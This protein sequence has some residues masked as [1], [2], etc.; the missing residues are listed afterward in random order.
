MTV[1]STDVAALQYTEWGISGDSVSLEELEELTQPLPERDGKVKTLNAMGFM[2]PSLDFIV[3][4]FIDFAAEAQYPVLDGGAAYG[5]ATIPALKAGATVIANDIDTRH[6]Q[7]IVKDQHLS[8]AEKQRLFLNDRALPNDVNFPKNSLSA[9]LLGRVLHFFTPAQVE[10]MFQKANDWL[11]PGGRFYLVTMTPYHYSLKG[12]SDIF[13]TRFAQG[14]PWP[15]IIT[16]MTKD[17]IPENKGKIPD[18]LH[19]IDA[20][21]VER[22]ATE[23]GFEV[24]RLEL[25]GHN[26]NPKDNN[27][28]YVGAIL[29]KR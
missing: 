13:E 26:R 17:Y 27:Q 16:T 3:E 9:I 4:D 19:V 25:F 12:F 7:L 11:V 1:L 20:R 5:V 10:S 2:N 6:L 28:G 29:V 22:L 24:E 21:I 8:H 15:G 18:Y 23:Y 14:D